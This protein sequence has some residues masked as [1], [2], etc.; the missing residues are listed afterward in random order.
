MRVQRTRSSPSALRSPL[1]RRPL[2]S[3]EGSH[4][5]SDTRDRNWPL[6]QRLG[7]EFAVVVVGVLVA[8]AVDAARDA[9]DD[10]ARE[11]AYVRQ[12]QADL[13]A[14]AEGLTEAISVDQRAREGADR[15]IEAINSRRLP[16][17]DSLVA[18]TAAATN[19]SASFYPT[20]GTVTA[21][22]ESGELRLIRDEALRQQVLHYHSS[23]E[24]ALRIVDAVDPHT[25]R[26]IERLGGML[27]WAA[28]L[29]RTRHGGFL[30]TGPCWQVIGPST[31]PLR[32][33]PRFEQSPVRI[34]V[35]RSQSSIPPGGIEP[36]VQMN[37]GAR[38]SNTI[39]KDH[40]K[41]VF[42][43]SAKASPSLQL[44]S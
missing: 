36:I 1:T 28:L 32:S 3:L 26:T 4:V 2:E 35:P 16:P 20:M 9:R 39:R 19:S 12:L 30:S 37:R 33:A 7:A 11:T 22:V 38:L 17:S 18:W 31:R 40:V 27:S 13:L 41:R 44:T 34:A 29:N 43:P 42:Y 6:W 15:A 8:L 14:T 25:W 10:R 5:T 24:S 21:L 23:V